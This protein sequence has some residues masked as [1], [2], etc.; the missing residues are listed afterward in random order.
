MTTVGDLKKFIEELP[1]DMLI[2]S[3]SS[4]FE[5][6]GNYENNVYMRI[7]KMKEEVIDCYDSF[8]YIH[9]KTKVVKPKPDGDDMLVIG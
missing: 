4:N 5:L 9:Y 3:V 8:D 1:D 7:R 6:K 2:A